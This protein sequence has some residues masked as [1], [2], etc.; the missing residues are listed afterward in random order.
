[1]DTLHTQ[2]TSPSTEQETEVAQGQQYALHTSTAAVGEH[3]QKEVSQGPVSSPTPTPTTPTIP[4]SG[5]QRF[6]QRWWTATEPTLP[7]YIAIHMAF[8]VTSCF[9]FLFTHKDF[10]GSHITVH[11]LIESWHHWDTGHYLF[12][13]Q[14][15]YDNATRTAFFP[16][17]PLLIHVVMYIVHNPMLAA[18][19]VSNIAGLVML[20]V[21]YQLVKE[22]FNEVRA[23]NAILYLSI[24]PTAFF[25]ATGYNEAL[26]MCFTVLSFYQ[27][28]RG[29]WWFAGLFGLFACLTRL[30]GL[31]LLLPFCYEYL[32]QHHYMLRKIRFD[33]ISAALIP[34]GLGIFSLYCYI[35]FHDYLAFSH[36]QSFWN[37]H[38]EVPWYG[39]RGS[40]RAIHSSGGILSFQ[41]LRNL[42]DL[43]PDLLMPVLLV[44]LF[45][46]PWRFPRSYWSYGIYA[47]ILY[48][49]LQLFPVGGTGLYPLQSTSRY[50]LELFPAFIVLTAFSKYRM[51]H[52]NYLLISGALLFF[53]LTQFLTGHWVL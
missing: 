9:A 3:G 25:F 1:M 32:R 31:F 4:T 16:L 11:D 47:I 28:R 19:L 23:S 34:L 36:A 49:F 26:F 30:A 46:G 6:W 8:F 10:D 45:I 35:R 2:P 33:S 42:L 50:L 27:M 22:D 43:V 24:F 12:I 20:V 40:L 51:F 13:A 5:P 52:M 15:G 39:I 21:L 14:H 38:L 41:A 29:R 48:V 7:T 53:L 37:H 44:L 18:L 17:H